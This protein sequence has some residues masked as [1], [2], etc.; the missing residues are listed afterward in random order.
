MAGIATRMKRAAAGNGGFTAVI[1]LQNTDADDDTGRVWN[2]RITLA[3]SGSCTQ[4]GTITSP[5]T[6]TWCDVAAEVG[7]FEVEAVVDSGPAPT[8]GPTGS[9]TWTSLGANV[10]WTQQEAAYTFTSMTVKVRD[11]ASQT[12]QDTATFTLASGQ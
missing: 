5:G 4:I 2:A 8:S 1:D 12:V 3:T 7:L 9:G 10:E 11:K 6:Y